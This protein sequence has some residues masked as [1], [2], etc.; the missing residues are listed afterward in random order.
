MA[1]QKNKKLTAKSEETRAALILAARSVFSKRGV[2]AALVSEIADE[3][4]FSYGTF[5]VYFKNK[6]DVLR[7]VINPALDDLYDVVMI[8]WDNRGDLY[9]SVEYS[10]RNFL[11][12]YSRNADI[13]KI[14][15][16]DDALEDDVIR[17]LYFDARRRVN[18]RIRKHLEN[19]SSKGQ[20]KDV[21]LDIAGPALSCMVDAF[22]YHWFCTAFPKRYLSVD[23]DELCKT[24]TDVWC[25]AM[26]I[27]GAAKKADDK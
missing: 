14:L 21:N 15:S 8:S 23:L 24:L 3:A 5:Y 2:S 9:S 22:A 27:D 6:K 16:Q 11:E 25:N 10:I 12:A 26:Y 4:G 7:E 17:S 20:V 19:A 1:K 18:R 13:M